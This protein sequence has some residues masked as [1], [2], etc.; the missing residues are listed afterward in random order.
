MAVTDPYGDY[1]VVDG[2]R[3]Q[4][5][6]QLLDLNTRRLI[7]MCFL[8]EEY[9]QVC[10]REFKK[11]LDLGADGFLFDE[12]V[13]HGL[14]PKLCFSKEHGHRPGAPIFAN[15][16]HIVERFQKMSKPV[17]PDFC[18]AGEAL[19]DWEYGAYHLCYFRTEKL[20]HVPWHRY[21]RPD[22]AIMT[23]VTGFD[24]REMIAQCLLYKY[25]ISYE[26][27][28][29]KGRP[30]DYPLT[31]EYGKKMDA[32]RT[33]LRRWF[34]D[35]ECRDTLGVSVTDKDGKEHHPYAVF[36]PQ[37]GGA[38]GVAIANYS[39][40]KETRVTLEV[41]GQDVGRYRYRLIDD[42]EWKSG[43]DG[44]VIPARGA[45]VVVPK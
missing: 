33:E 34:W 27:F 39:M 10:E 44:I 12:C 21:L 19:Y 8:N 17:N 41:A 4:T 31:L 32:L 22:A 3:Y 36:A 2:Y 30:G 16:L 18:Y 9:L 5:P 35:G 40:D 42:A 43:K 24:D 6:M 25:I 38:P 37:D 13:H 7:P 1:Q 20:S 23:A 45:A 15:D 14:M 11:I 28:N 29:F 26:P